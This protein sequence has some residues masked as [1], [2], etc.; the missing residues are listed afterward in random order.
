MSKVLSQT[1]FRLNPGRGHTYLVA[2]RLCLSLFGLLL[3]FVYLFYRNPLKCL[4]M[5]LAIPLTAWLEC[6]TNLRNQNCE[7]QEALIARIEIISCKSANFALKMIRRLIIRLSCL[8]VHALGWGSNEC[9]ALYQRLAGD[10][11]SLFDKGEMLRS[12]LSFKCL[13]YFFFLSGRP[14]LRSPS[15]STSQRESPKQIEAGSRHVTHLS[16]CPLLALL[17]CPISLILACFRWPC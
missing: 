1:L 10:A 5:L 15:S 8:I 6:C 16:A 14:L 11:P 2:S 7:P 17:R 12:A 13:P 3:S 9:Q 4:W